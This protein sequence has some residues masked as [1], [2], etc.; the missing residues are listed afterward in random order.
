MVALQFGNAMRQFCYIK[1]G[2]YS[3]LVNFAKYS[4]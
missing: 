3:R 2:L 4:S 1:F